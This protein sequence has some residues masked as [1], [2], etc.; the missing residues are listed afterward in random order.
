[1]IKSMTGFGRTE[2]E[3]NSKKIILEIKSLNS[4][5]IDINIRI[6]L[7][8]REKETELRKKI[9]E[10]LVRGK[11]DLTIYIE[12]HGEDS[13][14]RINEQILKSYFRHIKQINK[15]LGLTTDN[16]TL[17]SL[18]KLPDVIKTE[19]ES[20]DEE[21]WNVLTRNLDYVLAETDN[22]RLREG[23]ALK[24]DITGNI[25]GIQSLLKQIGPFE[26]Q[27]IETIKSRLGENL[28]K[29]NLNGGIDDNRFE[30][31][32]IYYLDKMDMN[33]EKVRLDNH[34]KYFLETVSQESF[35][36]KKLSFI[37]QEIGRE[38]NTI[39]SKAYD[40]N[41]QRIVVQMKDHLERVKEQLLNVL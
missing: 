39:G 36:G 28:N 6:P 4:K 40:S 10:K 1:M 2:F 21:E 11:I 7:I 24:V 13:S 20:V 22:F 15:D 8:Y 33:E 32:L 9:S 37:S 3:V 29:A 34:C 31:E 16:S 17:Q 5:Q 35:N 41:I 14:S 26:S 12:N 25:A 18:L 23:T 30:Q 38:I 19:F 27:R